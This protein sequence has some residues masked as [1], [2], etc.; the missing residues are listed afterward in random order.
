[1]KKRYW[2]I[3]GLMALLVVSGCETSRDKE[4]REMNKQAWDACLNS[5][6]VP[7]GSWFDAAVLSDCKYKCDSN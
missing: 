3:V 1:M 5:G 6:G 4:A 7:L 2:L